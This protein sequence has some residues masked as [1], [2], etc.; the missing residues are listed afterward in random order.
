MDGQLPHPVKVERMERLVEVVQRRATERAQRF[1]GRDAWRCWSKGT[2]RT[3]ETKLRGRTRHDKAVNFEGVA[4]PGELV[5]V[6]IDARHLADA[7]RRLGEA[8]LAASLK[9]PRDLRPDRGR[10]D[11][12][13]D[14][15]GRAAAGAR[16]GPGGDLLRRAAGL[17]GAGDA[18]RGRD[19]PRSRRSSSTGCSASCRSPQAFSVGDYMPLA[20]AEIDAALAAGRTADRGRGDR[21]LPAGGA[22]RALAGQGAAGIGGLGAL[23]AARPG[24]RRRSSASTWTGRSST[25]GSTP[26]PRRSSPP[27]PRRRRAAPRR[28]GPARTARK[29]LGFDELLAGD[30]ETMKKRSRNYARRQLTWMRK[31]PNLA[32]D[33]PHRPRATPRSPPRSCVANRLPRV[34][35]EK[36]QALGNDY[37]ILERGT[38]PLGA[39]RDAGRV[40]LRPAFRGRRRRGAAARAQRGPGVRR[41]AADLQPGRLRGRALR[42]RRPRGDP[43][44]A[45]PRLDRRGRRSRSAPSPGRSGRR[46]PA[47]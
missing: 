25:S 37:L 36:W 21:A 43:L 9:R 5:E 20:H 2:S 35:F 31:I 34:K 39:D 46:S 41:R 8:A 38:A 24:T 13:R 44:P 1:V 47:S 14:R 22:G 27:G 17:R 4:E 33:R 32:R 10:E 19:A 15:A 26:G 42:Q 6:E 40:A 28:S 23:V 29:A 16:R 18:D 7:E 45:P 12:G 3:D 30:L 11:R